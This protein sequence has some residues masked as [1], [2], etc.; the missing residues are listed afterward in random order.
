MLQRLLGY[1]EP[2]YLHVPLVVGA[3][4]E[5]LAKRH[6]AVTLSDLR[7][8]GVAVAEVVSWIARSL[9]LAEA[10]ESVSVATLRSRFDLHVVPHQPCVATEFA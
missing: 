6:G 5:R 3:D 7:E 1:D 8:Q 2:A 9:G 10:G 4:G